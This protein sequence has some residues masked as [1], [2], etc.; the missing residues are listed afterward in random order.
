MPGGNTVNLGQL[1]DKDLF[2]SANVNVRRNASLT[3]PILTNVKKGTRVGRM[4]SWVYGKT[5]GKKNNDIW[6]QLYDDYGAGKQ[7]SFV[8]FNPSYFD[9]KTLKEQGVKTV[10]EEEEEKKDKDKTWVDQL[11][12]AGKWVLIAWVGTEAIKTTGKKSK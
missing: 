4:Y 10:K 8:L 7:S 11:M 3:A 2:A 5:D 1:I 6:F 12:D 9:W